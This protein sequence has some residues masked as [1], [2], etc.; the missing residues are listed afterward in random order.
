MVGG[1]WIEKGSMDSRL[2]VAEVEDWLLTDSKV[3]PSSVSTHAFG[4]GTSYGH[5]EFLDLSVDP[6]DNEEL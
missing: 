3:C 5:D 4:T 6:R 2:S 1:R